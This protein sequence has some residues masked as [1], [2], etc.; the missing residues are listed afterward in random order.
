MTIQILNFSPLI[1]CLRVTSGTIILT[2]GKYRPFLPEHSIS[3]NAYPDA[4]FALHDKKT[5]KTQLYLVEADNM[6][7]PLARSDKQL[8]RTSNIKSK[9]II[10]HRA[11]QQGVFRQKFKF[12]ATRILFVTRSAE[13][14]RHMD[15]LSAEIFDGQAPG[16]F[17]F[18][19]ID[20]LH[21]ASAL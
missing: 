5:G 1:N 11:W 8:F 4:A 10:Y 17:Q 18:T 21:P 13:R 2:P 15:A 20:N 7:M 14:A 3:R 19:D 9:L 6:T 12:P 16:L